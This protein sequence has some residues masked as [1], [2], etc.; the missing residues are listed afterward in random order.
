MGLAFRAFSLLLV[1]A[2]F[3]VAAAAASL[4][5][6]HRERPNDPPAVAG[7]P[8]LA[9]TAPELQSLSIVQVNVTGAGLNIL[10]DAANE[11]SI[12][13]DPNNPN[14]MAI[15]WR[16]FDSI[17]SDFREAGWAY[18]G[19]GGRHWTF[20]GV[21]E[22]NVFRSDPVLTFASD[23]T[24]YFCSLKSAGGVLSVDV[25]ES[26]DGGHNW[27]PPRAA[28]G[29][30]KQW[31]TVDRSGGIGD[32]HL[33]EAWSTAGSCC[34]TNTF[35]RSAD[36]GLSFELPSTIPN[37][38]RWGTMD[39]GPNGVLYVA[40]IDAA[41]RF[42]LAKSSN[43]QDPLAFPTWDFVVTVN[44][45]GNMTAFAG[46]SPNPGGLLGQAA[47]AA[48]RSSGPTAGW[49]YMMCSVDPPGVDPMDVHF[50]RSVDG[51]A[52]WSAPV[53]VNDD[54]LVGAWQW[55]GTMSVAP[56]GRIDVIWNDTRNTAAVEQSQLFYASST[57]GG[58]T[59]SANQQL[60][61][62]WN[63]HVGWPGQDKI[64][65]YYHMVSD[66][67]GASLA[68]AATFNGE[69]DV[70]FL[71]IGDYDC[72]V[73]G[74]PDSLDLASGTATD[75][76]AN[77]IPDTCEGLEASDVAARPTAYRLLQNVPNPFN[78]ATTLRFDVP[79]A[80][81]HVRLAVFDVRGRPVRLL[82]E[83]PA[84]AGRNHVLWDGRDDAGRALASGVYYSRLE[85]AG[86]TRTRSLL[87][88]R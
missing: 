58:V 40:G 16:Q 71:R 42:R 20:A 70:Y 7:Q 32:G 49:V 44:M 26:P 37:N 69:Q 67:V 38:P 61:P 60:S 15:G 34:G 52:T 2:Q 63:S 1:A 27:F 73:N 82:V 88:V 36:G 3:P 66:A 46:T 65:D 9:P 80:G 87:L 78:P 33:Y 4:T 81:T 8:V 57:N 72:N 17:L 62:T 56:T 5:T 29:G 54:M 41:N 23:G 68:W 28:Y 50:V 51:G 55:F 11:P 59:W 21:L 12:A 84:V 24:F 85:A 31:M 47:V 75:W 14:R 74:V 83:G 22:Q 25:F 77:G 18:T 35:T 39:V 30:D 76:N 45:G 19:D 53:R 48:D 10:D 13:V 43:A 6:L 79:H 64:G 86:I